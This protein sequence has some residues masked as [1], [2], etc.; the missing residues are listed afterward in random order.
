MK[1]RLLV[2]ALASISTIATAAETPA[3]R[4]SN[5]VP[6]GAKLTTV[7]ADLARPIGT[8]TGVRSCDAIERSAQPFRRAFAKWLG[9]QVLGRKLISWLAGLASD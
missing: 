3:W 4:S 5:P 8:W 2:V 9:S 6:A 7:R 1:L